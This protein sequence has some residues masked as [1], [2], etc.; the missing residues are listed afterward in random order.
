M[1]LAN[2][3]GWLIA[4]KVL[5]ETGTYT[6]VIEIGSRESVIIPKNGNSKLFD[7]VDDAIAWINGD[8]K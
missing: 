5:Y 1:I 6:E 7:S 8:S 2:K 3:N 4:V